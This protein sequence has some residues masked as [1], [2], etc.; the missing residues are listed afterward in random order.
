M[1]LDEQ[2]GKLRKIVAER[3]GGLSI[4][5]DSIWQKAI[6][7]HNYQNKQDGTENGRPHVETVEYNIWCLLDAHKKDIAN[8]GTQELFYLSA[9]A[10]CHDFDKAKGNLN[11]AY[12]PQH[13]LLHGQGSAAF[14]RASYDS[15]RFADD[16]QAGVVADIISIHDL[17]GR[18]FE[19][20][21]RQIDFKNAVGPGT[22]DHRV[23]ALILKAADILHTDRTR[24]IEGAN[25]DNLEIDLD[26]SKYSARRSIN[27]WMP[28]GSRIV[29]QAE[30]KNAGQKKAVLE[31]KEYMKNTEWPCVENALGLLRFPYRLEFQI[32][33]SVRVKQPSQPGKTIKMQSKAQAESQ[34]NR[35]HTAMTHLAQ[36]ETD[37][38]LHYSIDPIPGQYPIC[39][40]EQVTHMAGVAATR[41][42]VLA[43]LRKVENFKEA[44]GKAADDLAG[45]TC[46]SPNK[47]N[48]H[49]LCLTEPKVCVSLIVDEASI[50]SETSGQNS[51][52]LAFRTIPDHTNANGKN[53]KGGRSIISDI[54]SVQIFLDV[55]LAD[56]NAKNYEISSEIL[57]QPPEKQVKLLK[58]KQRYKYVINKLLHEKTP[59]ELNR[60]I[61]DLETIVNDINILKAALRDDWTA[62]AVV[63][64]Q[65]G[66]EPFQ[67]RECTA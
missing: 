32:K 18:E 37:A 49:I 19:D 47:L 34:K 20:G 35:P 59:K 21:L 50:S 12:F 58:N 22:F 51:P 64:W 11:P 67:K 28:D 6:T 56:L 39:R 55:L 42:A 3:D 16:S 5:L 48:E 4:T 33:D 13:K 30:V 54:K 31:C 62:D 41:M 17:K 24:I 23:L 38:M 9:A 1:L 44:L 53:I 10:C 26:K 29:I 63:L 66:C 8:W 57:K 40:D 61:R 65:N 2:K 14:I 36:D 46:F 60:I 25:P 52:L 7:I 45:E 15:L 27:G 43:M